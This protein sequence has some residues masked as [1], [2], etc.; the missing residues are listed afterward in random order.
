[1]G[2]R[3]ASSKQ[4]I[5]ICDRC[6][7]RFRLKEL[8]E[9]IVKTKKTNILACKS[10]WEPDH[11]QLQLGMYP[12]DDPQALRNPRPD[13]TYIQSGSNALGSRVT[14]FGLPVNTNTNDIVNPNDFSSG[15]TLN[16][17]TSSYVTDTGVSNPNR[18]TTGYD[19]SVNWSVISGGTTL[20]ANSATAPD[21]TNTAAT[22]TRIAGA[23]SGGI[24]RSLGIAV[25][26]IPMCLSF[27]V[28]VKP[29]LNKYVTLRFSQSTSVIETVITYDT[30]TLQANIVANIYQILHTEIT[31]YVNGWYTLNFVVCTA[32]TG[33]IERFLINGGDTLPANDAATT[34]LWHPL[35]TWIPYPKSWYVL[36]NGSSAQAVYSP[37]TIVSSQILYISQTFTQKTR[38]VMGVCAKP[39]GYST[40]R[41]QNADNTVGATFDVSTGKISAVVGGT[42]VI[43]KA[44]YIGNGFWQ[45]TILCNT[46]PSSEL[47]IYIRDPQGQV[48]FNGGYGVALWGAWVSDGE[49]PYYGAGSDT[50]WINNTVQ[51]A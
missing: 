26:N 25:S 37:T 21:G 32:A 13:G 17:T 27:T 39:S 35:I 24:R 2:N 48:T 8:R 6:G 51:G 4:A 28:I 49:E 42:N 38:Y 18:T 44:I 16:N 46:I 33:T 11:P 43:P 12:V 20:V 1:M 31:P 9:L 3:F 23:A 41:I 14:P 36:P 15:W 50:W 7:F 47:R 45:C 10:C 30:D 19:F 40:I 22:L 5:S 29:V 34:L